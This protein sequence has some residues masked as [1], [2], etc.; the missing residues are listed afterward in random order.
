MAGEWE[1][2][3]S[4]SPVAHLTKTD[5]PYKAHDVINE[6]S[7]TALVAF[8]SGIFIASIRNAMMRKNVGAWAVFTRGAPIIGLASMSTVPLLPNVLG[9]SGS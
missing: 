5:K 8:G 7:K 1:R 6:T 9:E 2:N 3:N 4:L